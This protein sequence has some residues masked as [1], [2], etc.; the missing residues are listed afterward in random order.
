MQDLVYELPRR[1][2]SGSSGDEVRIR[3]ILRTSP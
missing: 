1:P 2:M 3:G